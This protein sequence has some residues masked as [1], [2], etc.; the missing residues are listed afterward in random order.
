M[1]FAGPTSYLKGEFMGAIKSVTIVGGGSSGWMMAIA[2]SRIPDLSV[3]LIEA[4][5]IPTIGVGESTNLTMRGFNEFVGENDESQFMRASNATYKLAIRFQNFNYLGGEFFHPFGGEKL[6]NKTFFKNNVQ[7]L[8]PEYHIACGKNVFSKQSTYSYHLDAG[9][10]GAYL[11]SKCFSKGVRHIVD[12]VSSVHVS[13]NGEIDYINTLINGKI[14]SDLYVDCSG[15]RSILIGKALQEPFLDYGRYLIN[16]RALA[17]RVPYNDRT[18][19]LHP[20][21]NCCALSSGW[22]WTIPL[23]NRRGIGYVYSSQFKSEEQAELELRNYLK[24]T[25]EDELHINPVK[26]RVGRHQ[27]AWVKNCVGIGISFGFLEPLEST[28]LS[29]TQS[30][31]FDLVVALT[32]GGTSIEREIFNQHQGEKFDRTRD[33]ILAHY[34]LTQRED[35]PYWKHIKYSNCIPPELATI[36][37][38]ARRG[39]F[40]PLNEYQNFYT[41]YNWNIILSGMQFFSDDL[42]SS[43]KVSLEKFETHEDIL[44]RDVYGSTIAIPSSTKSRTNFHPTR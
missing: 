43:K 38:A 3:T 16:D 29:L 11:K 5:D 22:T 42:K 28:G 19:E 36:L 21:T 20:Y 37:S 39:N 9:L 23:W 40:L 18:T 32:S 33:F 31:I 25:A 14:K 15:F 13:E 44:E 34:V 2:L 24:I 1:N 30:A 17:V 35:T 12:E 4:S 6:K 27:R 10:Y 8:H 41:E 7:A 26:I